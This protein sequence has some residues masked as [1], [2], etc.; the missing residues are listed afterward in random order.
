MYFIS[1]YYFEIK[2]IKGKESEIVDAL[3]R[4]VNQIYATMIRSWQF[5]LNHKIKST[6]LGDQ[7][8]EK[9]RHKFKIV[10]QQEKD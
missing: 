3:N 9:L 5:D 4:K 7:G 8:Y 10:V 2:H 1:E 6:I